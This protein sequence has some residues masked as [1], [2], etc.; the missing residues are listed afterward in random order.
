LD[1][2][3]SSDLLT[4]YL[5]LSQSAAYAKYFDVTP[6]GVEQLEVCPLDG[7]VT[8]Y[9]D[10]VPVKMENGG[11]CIYLDCVKGAGLITEVLYIEQGRLV[12]PFYDSSV[13]ATTATYRPALVPCMDFLGD[14]SLQIPVMTALPTDT[15]FS[16]S[17]AYL[18]VWNSAYGNEL[19]P[20]AYTLMN[21]SDGYSITLTKE[22]AENTTTVRDLDNRERIIYEYDYEKG[23][24]KSELLRVKVVSKSA[25]DSGIYN[26]SY[27]V[28]LKSEAQVWLARVSKEAQKYDIKAEE[29]FKPISNEKT[30]EKK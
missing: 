21:Y 6:R 30:E 27:T 1:N 24:F 5:D 22:L 19:H 20:K 25:F 17:A 23:E 15:N 9:Y 16:S 3:F 28:L 12:A 2:G 7:N 18:T 4:V 10:P 13:K 11:Y 26:D 14:G 29:M 8:A